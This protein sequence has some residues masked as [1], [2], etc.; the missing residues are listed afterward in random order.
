M[1][2][3]LTLATMCGLS[4]WGRGIVRPIC[5]LLGVV[6]SMVASVAAGLVPADSIRSFL[7]APIL[8]VPQPH[9]LA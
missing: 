8:A 9:Y 1:I 5:S 4:V 6:I 2:S 7:D 3:G